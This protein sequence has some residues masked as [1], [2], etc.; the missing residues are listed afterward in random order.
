MVKSAT[1]QKEFDFAIAMA[2]ASSVFS[3]CQ[4]RVQKDR[5]L[6]LDHVNLGS[7]VA[8]VLNAR[9]DLTLEEVRRGVEMGIEQFRSMLKQPGS[10]ALN[11]GLEIELRPADEDDRILIAKKGC[12]YTVVS[13]TEKGLFV[14]AY[15]ENQIDAIGSV[16]IGLDELEAVPELGR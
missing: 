13:Y 16:R 14:D 9:D 8:G 10:F 12:G 5:P 3:L 15:P 6:V 4:R 1:G 11:G 2:I 7:V